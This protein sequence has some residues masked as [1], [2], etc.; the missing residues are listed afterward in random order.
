MK[1]NAEDYND[2]YNDRD[3]DFKI[4]SGS[5]SP[6][7]FLCL[8]LVLIGSGLL[9]LYSSTSYLAISKNLEHYYY[10]QKQFI[11]SSIGIVL[12]ILIQFI[13]MKFF[14]VISYPAIIVSMILLALTV[15]T[16]FGIKTYGA[17]RWLKLPFL[18]SFQ[19]SELTKA[20]L[21][22]FLAAWFSEEK[23]KKYI[24]WYYLVPILVILG[25]ITLILLQRAFTTTLIILLLSYFMLLVC[26]VKFRYLLIS[27]LFVIPL[28]IVLLFSQSYRIKRFFSFLFPDIDTKGINWQVNNSLS[29]IKEGGLFGKGL[30]N[31]EYKR[32]LLPEIEN[33]FIFSNIGEELGLMGM[34]FVIGLFVIFLILGFRCYERASKY[35][36]YS[37]YLVFGITGLISIQ[38]IINLSVVLGL[39][40]PTGIPLPFFSLGGTNLLILISLS[41][42]LYKIMRENNKTYAKE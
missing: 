32:G 27:S 2:F 28:G 24:G 13:P 29:A 17:T 31:G 26:K 10:F 5:L 16:S 41:A 1:I 11:F 19:P 18:P 40:P 8:L 23:F 37:A 39:L 34:L 12:F 42:L 9:M 6:F 7:T 38:T 33:D 25:C 35:D 3:S 21:I 22:L 14:K 15:F 36:N 4:S 20:S 30:G